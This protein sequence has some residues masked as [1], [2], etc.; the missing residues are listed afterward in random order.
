MELKPA[1][2]NSK[3]LFS[4]GFGQRCFPEHLIIKRRPPDNFNYSHDLKIVSKSTE[5]LQLRKWWRWTPVVLLNAWCFLGL[6][7]SPKPSLL[8]FSVLFLQN[9]LG[10][11]CPLLACTPSCIA[12]LHLWVLPIYPLCSCVPS[13]NPL[14][15]FFTLYGSR[16]LVPLICLVQTSSYFIPALHPRLSFFYK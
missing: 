7:L 16:F 8:C 11:P 3:L 9:C 1:S 14:T 13:V 5:Y 2:C 4:A 15:L 12:T 10:L 6:A